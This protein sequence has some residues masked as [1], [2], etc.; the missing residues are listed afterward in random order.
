[1]LAPFRHDGLSVAICSAIVSG[2]PIPP[3]FFGLSQDSV[4]FEVEYEA[5]DDCLNLP[6]LFDVTLVM[7]TKPRGWRSF[8]VHSPLL[9]YA[10][11]GEP[12]FARITRK[13]RKRQYRREARACPVAICHKPIHPAGR[14]RGSRDRPNRAAR[15][16]VTELSRESHQERCRN[17]ADLVGLQYGSDG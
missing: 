15:A 6:R 2:P 4:D 7:R 17:L 11:N 5:T 10:R 3:A 8:E 12:V 16:G 1:M 9:N 14:I 13:H